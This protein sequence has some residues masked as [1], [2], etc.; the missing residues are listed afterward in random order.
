MD[1][2]STNIQSILDLD[3]VSI[4]LALIPGL[5]NAFDFLVTKIK[6][7]HSMSNRNVDDVYKETKTKFYERICEV[8]RVKIGLL[9]WLKQMNP[10]STVMPIDIIFD[11]RCWFNTFNSM[12]YEI[13]NKLIESY[14]DFEFAI[15]NL[16]KFKTIFNG[17]MDKFAKTNKCQI[18]SELYQHKYELIRESIIKIAK[19]YFDS[20]KENFETVE[21]YCR[22][23]ESYEPRL[24]SDIETPIDTSREFIRLIDELWVDVFHKYIEIENQKLD[25]LDKSHVSFKN[26]LDEKE[27]KRNSYERRKKNAHKHNKRRFTKK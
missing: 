2:S 18:D 13:S 21:N 8:I 16:S 3:L 23:C 12:Y 15:A 10:N 19:C 24:K 14:Y 25:Y 6:N 7:H 9:D 5:K 26:N 11:Y 4:A 20:L 22:Y 27:E 17:F 1:Q